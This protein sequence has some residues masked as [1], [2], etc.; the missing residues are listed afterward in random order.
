MQSLI[1]EQIKKAIEKVS[2]KLQKINPYDLNI[3]EYNQKYLEKYIENSSFYMFL[4][5]QLLVKAIKKL[6]KPI[7]ESTF[8][9]YGGGSGILSYLAKEI[10]FKYVVYNDIYQISVDDTLLISKNMDITIDHYIC[11]DVEQFVNDI[12]SH[13]IKPD[14]ICSFDVL[15]H[16]YSLKRWFKT[17]TN[18][19]SNFSL[20]FMTSANS[21]NP[22]IANRLKKLQ[23][24]AEYKGLERKAGWKEIDLNTS[25]LEARKNIIRKRFP[26]LENNM[27]KKLSIETRGLKEDDIEVVVKDYIKTG[28]INYQIKHP[29]NTCDP[30]NG[31]RTE[32]LID[33]KQLKMLIKNNNLTVEITNSLYSYSNNKIL[34]IPKYFLN[35][36]IHFLGPRHLLLS[37]TYT[38]EIQNH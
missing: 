30:Y 3:S 33:L 31:N 11:G 21:N 34:N 13:S 18:I 15:E 14:L 25:F 8:I 7:S 28:K 38:L 37:P 36:I 5:S 20:L 17:I 16:I 12:N 23:I 19:E 35:Q 29:T 24:K 32:N 1:D 4:Y 26:K 22:Y 6:N 27:V 2:S 10:G 9:D